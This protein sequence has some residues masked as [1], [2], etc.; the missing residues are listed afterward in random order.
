MRSLQIVVLV[1]LTLSIL[2][3]GMQFKTYARQKLDY[4]AKIEHIDL[5][6]TK[7]SLEVRKNKAY[8]ER[9]RLEIAEKERK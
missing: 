6:K 9:L 8:E 7:L 4:A 1:G 2:W 5:L 3:C